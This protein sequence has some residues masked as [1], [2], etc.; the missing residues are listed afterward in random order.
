M[1]ALV[2]SRKFVL[3]LLFVIILI[4]VILLISFTS[5]HHVRGDELGAADVQQYYV[6]EEDNHSDQTFQFQPCR[7]MSYTVIGQIMGK[8]TE[9]GFKIDSLTFKAHILN[10]S[11]FH[12]NS[13][14][15]INEASFDLDTESKSV[16]FKYEIDF[17]DK[18]S[19]D[20]DDAIY[21]LRTYQD[22][23]LVG[24]NYYFGFVPRTESTAL[25]LYCEISETYKI[26]KE[27]ILYPGGGYE[28][29]GLGI[30]KQ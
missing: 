14:L 5:V 12:I 18:S 22:D 13:G 26:S 24:E 11:L 21:T 15:R 19:M 1:G 16:V 28:C 2:K 7:V 27:G 23:L 25:E 6:L 30:L 10:G 3:W 29:D 8:K 20:T 9:S 4:L 17:Y